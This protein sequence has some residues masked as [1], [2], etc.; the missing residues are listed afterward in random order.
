MPTVD[1]LTYKPNGDKKNSDFFEEYRLKVCERRKQAGL[2]DLLG[3]ITAL[4]IQVET[5]EAMSYIEELY[6][7]TPY[8]F[9]AAF[10][11][12][13]HKIYFLEN[14]KDYPYYI[15]LEPL[16]KNFRDDMTSRNMLHPNSRQK[17][18]ARYVGEIFSTKNMKET[19]RILESHDM[20]FHLADE[21]E[22]NF[23]NNDH[24]VFT[25]PSDYTGNRVGYTQSDI[26]DYKSLNIGEILQLTDVEKARLEV[27]H[28]KHNDKGLDKII[29]GVDHMA[30]RIMSNDRE[31][32]ILEFMTLSNYYFWGAYNIAAMNSST[33]V[34]RNGYAE[35]ELHSPAKVFTANNTPFVV[36]S[37][38]NRPMPTETFVRNYGRRMH[39]IA[40]HINDGEQASGQKNIDY[41]VDVL[42]KDFGI[43]FLA[44]IVG[45]CKDEPDLKQIFSHHSSYSLLITEYIQRCHKYEGFFTKQNVASL[46]EAAGL[47]ERLANVGGV[48]D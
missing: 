42:Q 5:G 19:Q 27:V 26:D 44:H 18:N 12:N 43:K 36:N 34:T 11:N 35:N 46:T 17:P 8:K 10:I 32:A 21:T 48:F 38:E 23:F 3:G 39:H 47:D 28:Q 4:V 2:D 20:R 29:A 22:N 40:Q 15:V 6:L 41:A 25:A 30:T 24:F 16:N 13:T 45:E 9:K 1:P 14:K 33:N 37:F 7:M 31:E